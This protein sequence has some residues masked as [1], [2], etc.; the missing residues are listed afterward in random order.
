MANT[1]PPPADILPAHILTWVTERVAYYLEC[2]PTDIAPDRAL[3]AYGFDSVFALALCGDVEDE[4][5]LEV[6]PTLAWDH[7]TVAAIAARL[8][9]LL[10]E[11]AAA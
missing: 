1:A 7:P 4:Y 9:E 11:G 5:G 6:D 8:A 2:P 3:T 10:A